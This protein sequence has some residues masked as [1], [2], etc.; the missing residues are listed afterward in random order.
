MG[1]VLFIKLQESDTSLP[2]QLESPMPSPLL[3]YASNRETHRK[4]HILAQA[5][6]VTLLPFFQSSCIS[7]LGMNM[8]GVQHVVKEEGEE[9]SDINS[10]KV[11]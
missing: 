3:L 11:L 5:L 2:E 8:Y 4:Y 6:P 7:F 10:F 1:C 9:K